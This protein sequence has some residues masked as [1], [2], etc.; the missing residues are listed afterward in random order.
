[1]SRKEAFLRSRTKEELILLKKN[2][3]NFSRAASLQ[4]K[5][6]AVKA[7]IILDFGLIGFKATIKGEPAYIKVYGS[8]RG[9]YYF[10][11]RALTH[12]INF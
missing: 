10:S 3:I 5:G 6:K 8:Y 12:L 7:R 11:E 4:N 1:M 9:V 2:L